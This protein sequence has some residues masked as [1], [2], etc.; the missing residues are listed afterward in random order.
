[1]ELTGY[2]TYR[3]PDDWVKP[4]E[5]VR[6]GYSITMKLL[7]GLINYFETNNN[8]KEC[9]SRTPGSRYADNE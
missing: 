5:L 9:S 4:G 2:K 1:M 6:V 7:T 3:E 8:L